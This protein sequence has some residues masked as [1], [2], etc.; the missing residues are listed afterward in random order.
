MVGHLRSA[1]VLGSAMALGTMSCGS[2]IILTQKDI[3][4]IDKVLYLELM[5]NSPGKIYF[6]HGNRETL[7]AMQELF[8]MYEIRSMER[9]KWSDTDQVID[10]ETGELG[11]RIALSLV[12]VRVDQV[13]MA[14]LVGHGNLSDAGILFYCVRAS[15][16]WRIKG[17]RLDWIS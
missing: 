10:A 2:R 8:P 9:V 1:V 4:E 3:R 13:T 14:A 7:D 17:Y 11:V 16:G 12:E 5:T 6:I 15:D